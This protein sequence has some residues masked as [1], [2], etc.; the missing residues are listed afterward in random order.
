[1]KRLDLDDA[2][3]LLPRFVIGV[4][5]SKYE[6]ELNK[7]TEIKSRFVCLLCKEANHNGKPRTFNSVDSLIWHVRG[8]HKPLTIEKQEKNGKTKEEKNY[9]EFLVLLKFLQK[10]IYDGSFQEFQRLISLGVFIR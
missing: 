9:Q 4:D 3:S 6:F 1:M 7:T 8:R 10:S 5:M 2:S